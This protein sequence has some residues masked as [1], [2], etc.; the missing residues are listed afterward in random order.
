MKYCAVFGNPIEQS[1]SPIIHQNFAQQFG[2]ELEYNKVLST[3]AMFEQDVKAFFNNSGLGINITAPFK[4]QAF[5]MADILS[6]KAKLA[7]AV[8]TLYIKDGKLVGDT[9]D[10]RGL[11]R[12]LLFHNVEMKGKTILL[13]GAGGAARGCI[14][15]LLEQLPSKLIVSN[16]TYSKAE[17]IV[18]A[19]EAD[20]CEA[21]SFDQV[22]HIKADIIINSTSCSLTNDILEVSPE[23]FNSAEVVYDMSYKNEVT[24]FN[25]W[26][27]ANSS[28]ALIIDGLGMLI[29]QAAES[30]KIW[31]GLQPNSEVLRQ[32][33]REN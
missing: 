8:N 26:A 5:E 6:A 14:K 24:S 12:D 4:H 25:H 18:N 10:G 30:F 33:L 11:V 23:I 1:K 28:N 17:D 13:L 3:P 15:D 19:V 2:I 7:C 21:T 22:N 9:T 16:R 20:N 32:T 31:H 29:E 27:I